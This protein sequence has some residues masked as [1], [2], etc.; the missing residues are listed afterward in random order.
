M[1]PAAA[2]VGL[3]QVFHFLTTSTF[4]SLLM[5]AGLPSEDNLLHSDIALQED[6]VTDDP[7]HSV[8]EEEDPFTRG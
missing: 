5:R 2:L 7:F 6:E 3:S 8:D 4:L 1:L